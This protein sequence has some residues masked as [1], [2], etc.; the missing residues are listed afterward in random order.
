[1]SYHVS[2]RPASLL[3]FLHGE[4]GSRL[5]RATKSNASLGSHPFIIASLVTFGVCFPT[6]LYV[7]SR[8]E[9]P[10]MP[11][12]LLHSAPRAN[13]IFSNALASFLLNAILFNA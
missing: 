2:A 7:E 6:C 9:R 11:L 3:V 1:M 4:M 8:A 13:I 5:K 10:I 12:V